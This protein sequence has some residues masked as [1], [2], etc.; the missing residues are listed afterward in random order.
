MAIGSTHSRKVENLEI[1]SWP[2][3]AKHYL[4]QDASAKEG[5]II[6][7]NESERV[8]ASN[9]FEETDFPTMSKG[10][11]ALLG[12]GQIMYT[13]CIINLAN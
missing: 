10:R 6:V 11:V 12:D 8:I 1:V 5:E 3:H 9:V 13:I 4:L 2:V 7:V